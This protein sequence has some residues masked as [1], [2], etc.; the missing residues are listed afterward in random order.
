M[1]SQPIH[2]AFCVNDRYTEY[3]MVPIKG[4]L[5]NNSSSSVVI[6]VLSDYISDRNVDKLKVLIGLYPKAKLDVIIVDDSKL[7]GLKDTWTIYTWYR[8]LLPE[9]LDADVHRVLYLDADVLVTGNI[10]KLF[11]LDMT[12]KAIAGTVDFQSKDDVTYTRCGYEKEKEYVCAGVMLMN[13]DYWRGHDIANK[14]ICWGQKNNDRIQFPDQDSINYIC[15]DVKVLLPLKY[16]IVDGFFHD[17]YYYKYYPQELKECAETP[18]I[19]HYAGQAPWVVELSKHLLQDEWDKYN[20]T[21][22]QPVRKIY[23]STGFLKFKVILYR[24]F[25]PNTNRGLKRRDVIDRLAQ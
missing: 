25:H 23:Q 18:V 2:V 15:Q 17:D 9:I 5:E 13:L 10:E 20:M 16:D 1:K 24:L 8:V 12:D 19:I 11:R 21:L 14:V 4:L 22:I 6:H 3:I 7:R